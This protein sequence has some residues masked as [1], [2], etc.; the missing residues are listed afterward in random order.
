MESYISYSPFVYSDKDRGKI[1]LFK[2][3]PIRMYHEP[4]I[5]WWIE[6]RG[7]DYKKGSSPHTWTIVDNEE[8]VEWFLE[9]I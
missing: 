9:K 5:E 3:T 4:D 2:S 7:K 6:N 8:L 1:D